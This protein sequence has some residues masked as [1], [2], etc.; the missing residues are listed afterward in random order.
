MEK[1]FKVW[2]VVTVGSDGL[3]ETQKGC[4]LLKSLEES[5]ES[6]PP[7]VYADQGQP[8][9]RKPTAKS[10]AKGKKAKKNSK[11][12]GEQAKGNPSQSSVQCCSVC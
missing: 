4:D 12:G 8:R 3:A 1:N 11:T 5:I 9:G 10:K 6:V 7:P 2:K